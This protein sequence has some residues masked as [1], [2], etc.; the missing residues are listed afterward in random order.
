MRIHTSKHFQQALGSVS[1]FSR[2]RIL[3]ALLCS[4]TL[5]AAGQKKITTWHYNNGRTGANTTE[6]ILTPSNVKASTFGKLFSQLVDGFI[7]GQPLYL[8]GVSIPNQGIHNIVY[9][10]TMNDTVYAFDADSSTA[11]A[12]WQTSLL[13]YSPAGATPVPV[14]VKG[15]ATTT[16]FTQVGVV[17]TPVIDAAAGYL[18]LVAETYENANVVHRLHVLNVTSGQ[19]RKGSPITIT[20]SYTHAG[21]SY[22]FVDTHQMNRPGL[23]LANGHVYI[24]FGSPGCNGSDQG[25]IMSYSTSTLLQDGVFDDEP[26]G[27]WAA[28][29]QQGAGISADAAGRIYA[30]SG[31]GPFSAGVD[32]PVSVFKLAQGTG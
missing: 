24:G 16:K 30:A 11:P 8:P 13:S 7:I 9:V 5:Y 2:F 31:E 21:V 6:K 32:L 3:C 19:E 4:T 25:W 20:A 26:G 27:E 22:P 29:W 12:L 14:S 23:L 1:W 17:S 10:A 28:I 15:C 18:Y